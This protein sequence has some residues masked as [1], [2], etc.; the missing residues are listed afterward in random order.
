MFN[1]A[2]PACPVRPDPNTYW[3]IEGR[4]L[5]GEY[6]GAR[7]PEEAREK[8]AAF[9]KAGITVFIDLTE[10]HEL[11][12]YQP[13]LPAT[14]VEYRRFPIR[15]LGVPADARHL[16]EILDAIDDALANDRKVYVHCWGGIG[17]TGTVIACWLQ[18]QGRDP[19]AALLELAR[20]WR[21]VAKRHRRPQTPETAEQMAWVRGWPQRAAISR[22][23]GVNQP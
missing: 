13:L 9:L 14:G 1:P 5:A 8:I 16:Q 6:P 7:D 11:A 22:E 17:R 23:P 20:F 15:D 2:D 3:V 12:P 18:G 10:A 4:F 19:E 21:T